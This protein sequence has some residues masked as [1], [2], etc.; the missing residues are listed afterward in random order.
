MHKPLFIK[1]GEEGREKVREKKGGKA[2]EK[3]KKINIGRD[4]LRKR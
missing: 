1:N 4:L 2:E 3:G